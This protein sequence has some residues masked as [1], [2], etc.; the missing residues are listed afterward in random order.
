MRAPILKSAILLLAYC[1]SPADAQSINCRGQTAPDFV[2]ICT[3]PRLA[4]RDSQAAALFNKLMQRTDA[5]GQAALRAQRLG[6]Q[7]TRGACQA[8][9]RC[10][11]AAYDDQIATLNSMLRKPK[12][13]GMAETRPDY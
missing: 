5:T 2:A 10:M 8:D 1:A 7:R 9:R 3:D 4:S 12:A 13:R 11:I 6:F